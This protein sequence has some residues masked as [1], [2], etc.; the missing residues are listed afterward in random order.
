MH[1]FIR[2]GT[3]TI[4]SDSTHKRAIWHSTGWLLLL[5]A[6]SLGTPT[7][8]AAPTKVPS[9]EARALTDRTVTQ[10][11]LTGSP[12]VLI[13]TPT[14]EAGDQSRAWA[15]TIR[16]E[17]GEKIKQ[18]TII[19]VELP[20]LVT[21]HMAMNRARGQVDQKYWERTWLL[22]D[23]PFKEQLNIP[24]KSEDA[25][26]LALDKEGK[27]LARVQGAPAPEKLAEIQAAFKSNPAASGP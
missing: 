21:Q 27:V 17:F 4:P 6:I 25:F 11:D 1:S 8:F 14:S 22:T 15:S 23:S 12:S 24:A 3:R 7:V 5:G 13:V 20:F 18:R 16:S 2:P 9:F 26:V 10:T 19:A